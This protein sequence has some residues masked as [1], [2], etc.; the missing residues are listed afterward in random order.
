MMPRTS[1]FPSGPALPPT[2]D[3]AQGW[4]SMQVEITN[5]EKYVEGL[6]GHSFN[7]EQHINLYT[8]VYDMCTQKHDHSEKLYNKY[9]E[10]LEEYT[11]SRVLPALRKTYDDEYRLLRVLLERWSIHKKM[12]RRLSRIFYYLDRHFIDRNSLLPLE[13]V[14]LACFVDLVYNTLRRKA[15]EAVIAIVD[16]EREGDDTGVDRALLKNVKDMYVEIG[17]GEKKR[18][19]QDLESFMLK[20][21][22]SYYSRKASGWIQEYSYF[23]YIRKSE[24]CVQKEKERVSQYLYASSEPTLVKKVEHELFVVYANQLLEKK[25]S[26]FREIAQGLEPV[27]NI[28]KQHVEGEV[29]QGM[30]AIRKVI[31]VHDKYMVYVTKCLENKTIFHKS[32]KEAFRIFCSK[33]PGSSLSAETLAKICDRII[34][35]KRWANEELSDEAIEKVVKFLAYIS[36]DKDLFAEFYR[37]K[38]ARRLLLNRDASYDHETRIITKLKQQFGGNF[39]RKM[40][41]MVTDLT[42]SRQNQKSFE[43]YVANNPAANPGI[44]LNV[45]LLTTSVW[46]SYK[47]FDV[48]LPSEI[49]KCVEIFK[50]FY[51]TKH[52]HRKLTWLH[53]LGTCHINGKFDQKHIELIVSIH[54]AAVLLLF[55]TRDNLSYT[56]IQTQLDLS[57]EDLVGVLHSL[58]CAKYKILIKEP[59]TETVSKTDVFEVNSK[60]TARMSRVKIPLSHVDER[61]KVVEDVDNNRRYAIDASIVRIMKSKKVLG[62][63]QLVS[64]CVK[65]LSGLFKPDVIAIKKRIEELIARDYLER[66]KMN[67]NMFRYLP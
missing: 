19:E 53:S 6:P 58:S 10:V 65:Q 57:H 15:Q 29:G 17:M 13:E 34:V 55:N 36:D 9:R 39:T 3:F 27:A 18:Y 22:T 8:T 23:D 26:E 28:F 30:D 31:E 43:E 12:V 51:E 41:G 44:D 21:T 63:E 1:S 50:G 52:K 54:Q 67:P 62:H 46:P 48:N 7:S 37:K 25:H 35:L 56:D 47:T 20:G 2:I 59:A 4:R 42:S 49:V 61:K 60:F 16:K 14:G 38:L 40:E 66:D 24:E 11:N 33:V 45:T 64:E 5:L 32:L